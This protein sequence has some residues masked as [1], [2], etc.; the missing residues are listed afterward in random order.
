[1][2]ILIIGGTGSVGNI[3]TRH[4]YN[5][6]AI[7]IFS[8]NE[9]LQWQMKQDFPC[10]KYVIGDIRDFDA[11]T[12]AV[13]GQ[14][15]VIHLAALKHVSVCEENR[16]EAYKT[17]VHGTANVIRVIGTNV[18]RALYFN[19]DK[20][21]NHISYYGHTKAAA[22]ILW[23]ESKDSRFSEIICGNVINSSGSVLQIYK[24]L[25]DQGVR[26]LPVSHPDVERYF[27]TSNQICEMVDYFL[28]ANR[29]QVIMTNPLRVKI[30]DLVKALG[31]EPKFH[32]LGEVEKIRE[33]YPCD[34]RFATVD[35]I[36]EAVREAWE[37]Q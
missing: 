3:I 21:I 36:Y 35:E 31:C 14:D 15:I 12:D 34:I 16:V 5:D 1:M 2:K 4:L 24:S 23:N 20:A 11:V 6:H 25:Y 8:R 13:K 28:T 30:V 26:E 33:D 9:N 19:T 10:C 17:N 32:Q 29:G 22:S 18:Q 27:V 7:T 37:T